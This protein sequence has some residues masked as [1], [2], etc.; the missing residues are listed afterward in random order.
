MQF[1]FDLSPFFG[2][3]CV[4]DCC[5]FAPREV[6]F[7]PLVGWLDELLE[8]AGALFED[9]EEE[10]AGGLCASTAPKMITEVIP[11]MAATA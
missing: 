9:D 5:S 11:K 10:V 2:H 1:T 7:C 4:C 8:L 3:F 6:S